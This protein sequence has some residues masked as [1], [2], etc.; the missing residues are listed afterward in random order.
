M[1]KD[2]NNSNVACFDCCFHSQALEYSGYSFVA[3]L[4]AAA[5]STGEGSSTSS[6]SSSSSSANR[7][8]NLSNSP[9]CKAFRDV[10]VKTA[11][12]GVEEAFRRQRQEVRNCTYL[13]FC[14]FIYWISCCFVHFHRIIA[15]LDSLR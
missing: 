15:K 9:T 14:L 3:Q 6:N 7:N 5:G 4:P 11:L 10:L 2:K 12:E 8:T 1:E 13:I